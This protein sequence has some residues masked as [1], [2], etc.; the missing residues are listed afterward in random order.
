MAPAIDYAYDDAS[1]LTAVGGAVVQHDQ[2]GN[3]TSQRG[4][5]YDW[6]W[7]GRMIHVDG[8]SVLGGSATYT[9]DGDGI[10]VSEDTGDG[11]E[12]LLT[13]RATA[14]GLP[15]LVQAGDQTFLHLAEG[16]IESDGSATQYPL[17]DALG[18][19]RTVTSDNGS[20]A[21][22]TTYDAFGSKTDESGA[23][24]RFGYTG[25][26]QSGDLVH[27]NARDLNTSLGRFL[28]V[29]PVRPGAPGAVGWNEYTY[30]VNNPTTLVDP[31][32]EFVAGE[33]SRTSR[34]QRFYPR[35]FPR[36]PS[37]SLSRSPSPAH[38]SEPLLWSTR[39]RRRAT[40]RMRTPTSP[41]TKCQSRF[42]CH[43]RSRSR[44]RTKP[45]TSRDQVNARST[46][47]LDT[48]TGDRRASHLGPMPA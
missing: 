6:D 4:T 12:S 47:R 30:V 1:Q 32:G 43:S 2:A 5:T 7:L 33:Y 15:D 20:I 16:V 9:Y 29:D 36:S 17:S 48:T 35:C 26:P 19:I 3:V 41:T 10:R 8:S 40:A 23:Q 24:S 18:S 42:R 22:A 39:Q 21:G 45:P 37:A 25:A 44:P 38:S 34:S 28:S 14:D 46:V 13:D 31:T 11:T 27:L